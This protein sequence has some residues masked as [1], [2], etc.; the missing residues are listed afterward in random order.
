MN[1]S[2]KTPITKTT[3]F[4]YV[5]SVLILAIGIASIITQLNYFN[6]AVAQYVAQG[7]D[8]AEV[9]SQLMSSQL[10]PSLYSVLSLNLGIA[11][12][13]FGLG[14]LSNKVTAFLPMAE[15][16]AISEIEVTETEL[17]ETLAPVVAEAETADQE[18][19]QNQ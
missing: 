3:L 10:L 15:T 19:E 18:T 9:T 1:A 14:L 5:S 11:A 17:F 6:A 4:F 16:N 8:Q 12:V 7:Y 2:T 13:L